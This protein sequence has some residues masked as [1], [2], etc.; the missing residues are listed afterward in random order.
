MSNGDPIKAGEKTSA[1]GTTCLFAASQNF[2]FAGDPI[3]YVGVPVNLGDGGTNQDVDCIAAWGINGGSG[4]TGWGGLGEGTGVVGWGGVNFEGGNINQTG[5]AG[6]AGVGGPG[7]AGFS[8]PSDRS[9]AQGVVNAGWG[10]VGMG[11][12]GDAATDIPNNAIRGR[13]ATPGMGVYGEGGNASGESGIVSSAGL[14]GSGVVGEAPAIGMTTAKSPQ[15]IYTGNGVAGTGPTGVYGFSPQG[16]G[17][18]GATAGST[19]ASIMGVH[20]AAGVLGVG[21]PGGQGVV[22]RVPVA[23]TSV[24]FNAI[25]VRGTVVGTPPKN[26][27]KVGPY[28][29]WFDGPVQ[30]NG[31]LSVSD[32][33]VTGDFT[34]LGTKSAAVPFPDGSHRRLYCVESPECWF[35]DFGEAKLVKGKATIKLP[36]DFATAIKTAS[37]HVFLGAY[38]SSNGLH[39]SKRTRAGFVVEE[40]GKGKSSLKFSYRIVGK[41]KDI[42]AKRFARIVV[43]E[44]PKPPKLPTLPDLAARKVQNLP[45]RPELRI[46]ALGDLT[47]V[48]PKPSSRK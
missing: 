33:V 16:V 11:G 26:R 23:R 42:E 34:V 21:S 36:R 12:A 29:G 18:M 24:D 13:A 32:V 6:V 28:A 39:V 44:I 35:E 9:F 14:P 27:T 4:L 5:G 30:V 43:P 37:Y 45:G 3:L 15:P 20:G 1:F 25:A 10:V 19:H 31:L 2:N 22:G 7:R 41:R 17:V 38:G 48:A 40:Q 46:H 47:A 8:F